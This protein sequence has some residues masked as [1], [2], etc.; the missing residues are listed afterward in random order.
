MAKRRSVATL[1]V[2]ANYLL[3]LTLGGALHV[4]GPRRCA[5]TS[6]A[7]ASAPLPDRAG[8]PAGHASDRLG[9]RSHP[10]AARTGSLPGFCHFEKCPVCR[11]LAQ[12]PVPDAPIEAVACAGPAWELAVA[13]PFRRAGRVASAH[14]IRGPPPAA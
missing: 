11:F 4:H 10:K 6:G 3:A 9:C 7:S 14:Q 13:V 5:R 2:L 12:K 1:A 8:C